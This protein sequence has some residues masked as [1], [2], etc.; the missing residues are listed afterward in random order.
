MR[1]V[2]QPPTEADMID[3]MREIDVDGSGAIDFYEFVSIIAHHMHPSETTQEI[4]QAFQLFDQ[5]Q[6][7]AVTLDDLKATAEKYLRTTTPVSDAELRQMIELT[8]Q[9]QSGRITFDD[10]LHVAVCRNG[11]KRSGTSA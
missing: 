2:G 5:N 1:A 8:D 4:R 3:L 9:S 6:D 11:A 7:G 10:F